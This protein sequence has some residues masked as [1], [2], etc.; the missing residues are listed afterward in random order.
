[1]TLPGTRKLRPASAKIHDSVAYGD[2]YSDPVIVPQLLDL[3]SD[4]HVS[5]LQWV[6]EEMMCKAAHNG[7]SK[8]GVTQLRDLVHGYPDIWRVALT[9]DPPVRLP[10][11]VVTLQPDAVPIRVK[12][13]RYTQAQ[14]TFLRTFVGEL[15]QHGLAYRNPNSAWCS[16]P[17]QVP[18]NGPSH[19]RFTVDLRPVNNQTVPTAWPMPHLESELSS[20][21]GS[22][23]FATFDLSN[24]HSQLLLDEASRECQPFMTPDGSSV[25]HYSRWGLQSYTGFAWNQE[26]RESYEVVA[27]RNHWPSARKIACMA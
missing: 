3:P 13:R 10:P 16:A 6:I 19:F 21:S 12:L 27:S 2:T 5:E 9:A 22:K 11:L 14:K 26:C 8:I 18:K 17:L 24:G 1:L 7:M 23:C 4:S 25:L 20:V 15:V